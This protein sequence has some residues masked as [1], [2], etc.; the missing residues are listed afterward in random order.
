M[1]RVLI[2]DDEL[3]S[4]EALSNLLR[5]YCADVE[6][7][8]EA[9]GVETGFV[10]IRNTK[11]DAILLDISMEDGNAFDLLD[12]FITPSFQVVFVTAH[13]DFA[14][15]AFRYQALDY[16][17]KPVNPSELVNAMNRISPVVPDH[18]AERMKNLLYMMRN[19]KLS[20]ITLTSQEGIVFLEISQIS[21]LE[22]DGS[23]TTFYL[24][25]DEK[26]LVSRPMR[27]FEDLLPIDDFF[28]IHQSFIV[29]LTHVRGISKDDGF[30][31]LL[32]KGK[33]LPIARRR[34]EEFIEAMKKY[35]A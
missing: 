13:D 34:K 33:R 17:L 3:H 35:L 29:N 26:Y 32:T 22:S 5:T 15:K 6:I 28:K 4:R 30:M 18:Y 31:A 23:Y 20:R 12:R 27:E 21:H 9:D 11:P 10:L 2:I 24:S 1:K 25:N 14:M 19:E 8:G 16:L 7:C